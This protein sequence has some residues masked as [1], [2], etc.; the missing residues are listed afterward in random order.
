MLV[1]QG[2]GAVP[3]A[4]IPS[5]YKHAG[6]Q[7]AKAEFAAAYSNGWQYDPE[8]MKRVIQKLQSISSGRMM[9]L[10]RLADSTH[11]IKPPGNEDVSI[12]YV[13]KANLSGQTYL[14]LL[15]SSI[16]FLQSYVE[17][18]TKIDKAYQQQD[19][20]TL[21]SLRSVEV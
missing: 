5:H 11:G 3:G 9:E 14:G 2:G 15:E 18:L 17:T 16:Y 13:S 1:N 6:A 8:A 20:E 21:E 12:G 4:I 7:Q 19:E 10:R